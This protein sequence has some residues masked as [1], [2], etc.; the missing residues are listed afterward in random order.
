M[1]FIVIATV[2]F[3]SVITKTPRKL[4]TADI[5]IA[6]RGGILLVAMHVAIAFGASVHPFTNITPSVSKM[7][8]NSIGFDTISD[9]NHVKDIFASSA[10]Q[11]YSTPIKNPSLSEKSVR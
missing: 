8:I 5:I 4:N 6:G 2:E 10:A 11:I 1:S 7:V 3:I 9:T